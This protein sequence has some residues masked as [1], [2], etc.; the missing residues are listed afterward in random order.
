[1]MDESALREQMCQAA[2]QL[3]LRG[4]V[5]G[6]GGMISVETHRHR[7]LATPPGLRRSVLRPEDLVCVDV[8]GLDVEG[9]GSIDP[10]IWRLHRLA[11][12]AERMEPGAEPDGNH[13]MIRATA[14]VTPISLLAALRWNP[15]ATALELTPEGMLPIVEAR[16]DRAVQSALTRHR[17]AA[18]RYVGLLAVA[19]D[20][21]KL[22][23]RI[24]AIDHAAGVEVA[25]VRHGA[26]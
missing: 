4:L 7:Y 13:T 11:Y 22:L 1:M 6:D 26:R 19:S 3:W 24:E 10:A 15:E 16:D 9:G 5:V 2:Y 14:L 18:V 25:A 23:N 21:T 17:A 8:G 12:Q 20:L